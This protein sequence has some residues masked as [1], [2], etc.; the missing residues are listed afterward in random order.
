[1]IGQLRHV[2][3]KRVSSPVYLIHWIINKC[4][5][6]CSFCF[7]FTDDSRYD[8]SWWPSF[9]EIE[10][11]T[12]GVGP[13]L[14]NVN[15][16]GGEPFIRDDV[17]E[18]VRAYA[19]NAKIRSVQ[20]TTNGWFT[21]RVER[22]VRSMLRNHP[23]LAVSI[24]MSLDALGPEHDRVRRLPGLFER[25][26]NT[27]HALAALK[28]E[29]LAINFNVTVSTLNQDYLDEVYDFLTKQLRA[30]SI[31]AIAVR[32]NPLD[33]ATKEFDI[34][35][36]NAFAARIEGGLKSGELRGYQGFPGADLINAKNIL[37]RRHISRTVETGEYISPCYAGQLLAV[38]HANG[39][40][41][42]CEILHEKIGN[43]KDYDY[44]FQRLWTDHRQREL[45]KWIRDTNCHCS[46]ECAWTLNTLYNPRHMPRLAGTYLQLKLGRL[47]R[48]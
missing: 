13:E 11:I 48:R 22:D 42:P 20:I 40:V 18:I 35:K 37:A 30:T 26:V 6:H 15:L 27:F 21:T 5:A 17:A 36:Y 33:P 29:R 31:G 24:T 34:R 12:R 28:E 32:G 44:D 4:N 43:L 19:L 23:D 47:R 9:D 25:L 7:I 8:P 3:S 38:L 39:D 14:Y 45:A 41:Y 46:F 1:M 2:V 10:R 16:T